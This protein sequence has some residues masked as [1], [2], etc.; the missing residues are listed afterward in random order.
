MTETLFH[1]IIRNTIK[2][3]LTEY[4]VEETD[5]WKEDFIHEYFHKWFYDAHGCFYYIQNDARV[6][7]TMN[8]VVSQAGLSTTNTVDL[9]NAYVLIV[10]REMMADNTVI[11]CIENL[12]RIKRVKIILPL[13]IHRKLLSEL[14]PNITKYLANSY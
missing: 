10:A 11:M 1:N 14:C 5:W 7:S 3:N 8:L 2:H 9:F 6:Y 12:L 13:I 4:W